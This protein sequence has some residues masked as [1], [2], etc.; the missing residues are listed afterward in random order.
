MI[1][2]LGT[3]PVYQRS[4]VFERVCPNGVNR[5]ASVHD[6]A[7]GKSVNVARVLRTLGQDVVATG[8]VGAGARGDALLADLDRA[9]VHHNFVRVAAPARQC[10]TVIDRAAGTATE[11]VEESGAVTADDCAELARRLAALAPAAK[12][13]VMSGSLPPGAPESFYAACL[14]FVGTGH[15]AVL[16]ARRGPLREAI[17]TPALPPFV[18]KL[19]RDELAETVGRPVESDDLLQRAAREIAPHDGG[20]VVTAGAGDVIVFYGDIFWRV[21]T[22]S[23]DARSAVGS[24]DAFAAGMIVG[25]L[26]GDSLPRACVL[27]AACGAANAMTDLAGF[28][29]AADVEALLPRVRVGRF[30]A[31]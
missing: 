22:P 13:W 27:G 18:V 7:S 11:L 30:D 31:I 21:L 6:Y 16:D 12:G 8:F 29:L 14:D 17:R 23:V 10:V 19:N 24:G 15:P 3:T 1:V 9:G 25:L 4:M 26:R 28:V 20:V 5:A 2:C